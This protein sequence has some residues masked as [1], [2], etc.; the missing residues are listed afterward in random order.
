MLMCS[1]WHVAIDSL[2]SKYLSVQL[3]YLMNTIWFFIVEAF[4]SEQLWNFSRPRPLL[5]CV[6]MSSIR[7]AS[8]AQMVSLSV[9]LD[10]SLSGFILPAPPPLSLPQVWA[11][12]W[13]AV[14]VQIRSISSVISWSPWHWWRRSERWSKNYK[15]TTPDQP[16]MTRTRR[17]GGGWGEWARSTVGIKGEKMEIWRPA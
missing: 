15:P 1:K 3:Y 5:E 10:I 6:S 7:R 8:T 17:G 16:T 4:P 14:R 2:L 9:K 12:V 11:G 13:P